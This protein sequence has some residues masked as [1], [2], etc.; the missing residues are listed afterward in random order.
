MVRPAPDRQALD[1]PVL[2]RRD[3]DGVVARH[4]QCIDDRRRADPRLPD[5][6]LAGHERLFLAAALSSSAG[7]RPAPYPG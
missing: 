3:D 4:D 6:R 7:N 2:G 5:D 1:R